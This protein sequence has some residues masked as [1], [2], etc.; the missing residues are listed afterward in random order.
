MQ[1][2]KNLAHAFGQAFIP[3]CAISISSSSTS[4]KPG[5]FIFHPLINVEEMESQRKP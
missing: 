4:K 3:N 2:F 5:Y 1:P